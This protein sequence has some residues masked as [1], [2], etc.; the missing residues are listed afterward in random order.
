LGI[1]NFD[2]K[3]VIKNNKVL[4]NFE[5]LSDCF[6]LLQK[7][8]ETQSKERAQIVVCLRPDE[9][10]SLN[11]VVEVNVFHKIKNKFFS[12]EIVENT[13]SLCITKG[14]PTGIDSYFKNSHDIDEVKQ[15]FYDYIVNKKDILIVLS[16]IVAIA[17][18]I[19]RMNNAMHGPD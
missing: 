14:S 3:D 11:E 9:A 18:D 8:Y 2:V 16:I 17:Y 15:I 5:E 6:E 12:K 19:L 13:F 4:N 10:Y 1:D 7:S